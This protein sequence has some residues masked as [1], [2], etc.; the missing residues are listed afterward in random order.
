MRSG[1][2][3]VGLVVVAA[4]ATACATEVEDGF[5]QLTV[6]DLSAPAQPGHF[7]GSPVRVRPRLAVTSNGCV[8]VTVDGVTRMPFWPA[9]TRVEDGYEG[10]TG[11]YSITIPAGPTLKASHATGDTFT[12]E[13]IID[14]E[15]LAFETES[16]IGS[17]FGYCAVKAAP[18]AFRDP[19]TMTRSGS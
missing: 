6:A 14:E 12:A 16:K 2:L 17:F 19:S 15:G 4:L 10:R 3:A 8:V 7:T 9:G 18:I 13:G 5:G 11:D 1:A